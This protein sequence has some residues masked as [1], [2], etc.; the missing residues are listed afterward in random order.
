L[1]GSA[2]GSSTICQPALGSKTAYCHLPTVCFC[3]E[4]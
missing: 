3:E 4:R 2:L 1:S